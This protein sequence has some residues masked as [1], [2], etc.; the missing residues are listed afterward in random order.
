[1][2]DLG[3]P[4][5]MKQRI[6]QRKQKRVGETAGEKAKPNGCSC[7]ELKK[8]KVDLPTPRS[9]SQYPHD[10]SQPSQTPAPDDVLLVVKT[11]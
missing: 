3:I 5:G 11:T 9:T 1:M 10:G 4:A 6:Y 8:I 7:R 2:R